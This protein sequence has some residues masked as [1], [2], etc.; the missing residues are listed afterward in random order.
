MHAHVA[1]ELVRIFASFLVF[2]DIDQ[3][4]DIQICVKFVISDPECM[5]SFPIK[6]IT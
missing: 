5:N 2:I 3:T 6:F 4:I 1:I